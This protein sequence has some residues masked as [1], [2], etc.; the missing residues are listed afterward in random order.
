MNLFV[1]VTG[2]AQIVYTQSSVVGL[3]DG[4]LPVPSSKVMK[5]A[6]RWVLKAV[7]FRMFGTSVFR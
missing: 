6:D 1:F 3:G 2:P 5:S 4:Q 7:L